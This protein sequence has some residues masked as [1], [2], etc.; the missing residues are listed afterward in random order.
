[1]DSLQP[2]DMWL[3]RLHKGTTDVDRQLI[4]VEELDFVEVFVEEFATKHPEVI[5][6]VYDD[7]DEDDDDEG[8][9]SNIDIYYYTWTSV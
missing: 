3:F 4:A 2:S 5:I 9:T 8:D 6:P 7:E 1:M